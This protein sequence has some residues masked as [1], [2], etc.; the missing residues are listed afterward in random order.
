VIW[1]PSAVPLSEGDGRP[2]ERRHNLDSSSYPARHPLSAFTVPE[3]TGRTRAARD[4]NQSEGTIRSE[5]IDAAASGRA[6]DLTL[7]PA[8]GAGLAATGA[9]PPLRFHCSARV[10]IGPSLA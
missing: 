2:G 3:L 8:V 1:S 6:Q 4:L 9:L 7:E 10:T 5:I